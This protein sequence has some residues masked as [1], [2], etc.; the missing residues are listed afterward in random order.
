MAVDQW[1][2]QLRKNESWVFKRR[3]APD[4]NSSLPLGMPF[5]PKKGGCFPPINWRGGWTTWLSVIK[6]TGY[7]KIA[8]YRELRQLSLTGIFQKNWK[9]TQSYTPWGLALQ[10]WLGVLAGG[11][12]KAGP[13]E[14]MQAAA[15][16]TEAWVC[17]CQLN[18]F[19]LSRLSLAK[20][21][22][23][24]FLGV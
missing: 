9:Q 6:M 24:C 8:G 1:S 10:G 20:S 19:F 3:C 22:Q 4:F 7:S 14:C 13:H 11:G 15:T 12:G 23:V 16:S 21:I 2:L 18:F 17:P 5:F